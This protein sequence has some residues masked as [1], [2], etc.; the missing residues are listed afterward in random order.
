MSGGVTV[1]V[2]RRILPGA[3]EA[4]EGWLRGVIDV[5]S[6]FDGHG[7]VEVIKP[8]AGSAQ[9]DWVLVFRF[10]QQAQL[11][12]WNASPERAE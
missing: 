1:I 12:A 9:Q 10:A 7:G 4:F 8:S 3:T 6:G 11:D 2:R 5:A